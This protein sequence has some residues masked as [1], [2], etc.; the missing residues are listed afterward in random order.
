MQLRSWLTA[1]LW[2][3]SLLMFADVALATPKVRHGASPY[4][5]NANPC[6]ERCA[7]S[8]ANPGNW[9]AYPNFKQIKKCQQSV[10]YDFSLYDPVDDQD[11]NHRIY[12]CSSFGP[13]FSNLSN[14]TA[15]VDADSVDVDYEMGWWNEGFGL[16]SAGIRSL[17]KQT[18]QYLDNGHGIT[19]RPFIMFARSG[20]A[21]IG[22]FIGQGLQNQGLSS[23][24]LKTFED[25]LSNLNVTTPSLAMQLCGSGYDSSH[26]FGLMV[27]SNT[28]FDPIQEAIKNW[29]NAT[30]LSFSGSTNF[31]GQAMFTTPLVDT[32]NSTA[33]SN[34]TAI[35]SQ[36]DKRGQALHARAE[37]ETIQVISGDSCASLAERC[38][39]SA[40][41]FT[42]YN[43]DSSLC[44]SL[45]P[46]Q[47][48]CCTSGD[49]PDL[50]PVTNEDGSCYSY[51][52]QTDDNCANLAVE[53]GLEQ[54][55]LEDFNTN[56]WGWGGCELLYV[57]TIMCLSEGDPPFPSEIA[58]AI[59]GPQVPGTEAPDDDTDIATLNPCPL[60]ACCNIWGQ[61][62]INKDFCVDTNTGAPG[63]A[64][65]GT[66]GC[67]SNCGTDIV[68]GSGDGSIRIAYFEGYGLGRDCLFQ[69]A[70]QIDASAYTYIHFAFGTLTTDYEVEVGD[71]L[72]TYQFG[73]FKRITDAKKILSFGGWD[74][75]TSPS[76][77]FIF[78][79]GTTSANRLKM[80][81]NIANFIKKHELDGVDIDW[82]YPGAPDIPDIPA[83]GEDEG[84][85]YLAFLVI[86]KNLL[87][88]K[89]ISIAA[90]ASYW[91]LKQ[92]PIKSIAKIVDYI[93][94]MT[95]DL[96]GQWDADNSDSQEGCDTG[97]C[98][99]SQ[100]NLT[101]TK[102]SLAMITKAGV[103]SAKVIVGVTSYGRSFN[104]AEIGCYGPNCLYTGDR[105][106][107]EATKGICTGTAGYIAD[108]EIYEIIEDSS[109]VV[110]SY[111]DSTSNSNILV[112]DDNQWVS[113]MSSSTKKIR[114]TLYTAWAMGG[115]TDW[116]SDLQTYN[117]V[118]EFATSWAIFKEAI[119]AGTDPKTDTTVTGNWTD[120]YCDHDVVDNP[121][122]YTPSQRW[123]LLGCD[124]AW[125]DATR[126]YKNSY[127]DRDFSFS[128]SVAVIFNAADEA[129]CESLLSD[130][131]ITSIECG[132][133]FDSE[134]SGP[135][136]WLIWNSLVKIHQL[137]ADY[138]D[139][140]F[141]SAIGYIAGL[142]DLENKFAPVPPE[143]DTTWLLVL[144]DIITIGA[145]TAA[146]PFFNA[147]LKKQK[148]F[149]TNDIEFNNAKD[150][151][152]TLI[153]QSTTLAKDL[154]STTIDGKKWTVESQDSFS[155]YMGQVINGWANLTAVSLAAIFNG[156][157]S[158][159]DTLWDVISDG[160]LITGSF[161]TSAGTVTE[162]DLRANI[163]RTFY[164]YSI[165]ILWQFSATWAFVM[166]S[167]YS[168]SEDKELSSYLDD[169]TMEATGACYDGNQ[170]YL[171]YPK[172]DSTSCHSPPG[173]DSLDGDIFGKLTVEEL[174]TGSVRTYIKNG[175]KN[176]DASV[177]TTD[178][179]TLLSLLDIDIT[180]PGYI[181]LPVCSPERAY[182][183]WDT[184]STGSST[185]YPCDVPPGID[186]CGD[187][188]FE[189][190][191]SD[192]SPTVDDCKTII[193]NI[194]GDATTEWTT[195]VVGEEQREIAS[196]GSC[197]FGVEATETTGNANFQV[198]GQDVIDI[199][200]SAIN[201][202]GGSGN[203][204]AQGEMDCNGNIKDQGVKWGIYH[205]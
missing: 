46:K 80:A 114:Q 155:N 143:E 111:L 129:T 186:N 158:S 79:E 196:Y 19:D 52:I 27:T 96:H 39:I 147:F 12:A 25:N 5:R 20:K 8:G 24:A 203:I 1:A 204:G 10:F 115:T 37:C 172:G 164:A 47:H 2:A 72:S 132:T 145:A 61:C 49:L 142:S 180:T 38:G 173:L 136:G 86:L 100:V 169:D 17:V 29:A 26:I 128:E 4:Y 57:G 21:S 53:Y 140:L 36:N 15:A 77:Y 179:D 87:P 141:N 82:E 167:G 84:A 65:A 113:Y 190:N 120:F 126:I 205:T 138:H 192:A 75:S 74:F 90:P 44:S 55:D 193:T 181:R 42:K 183:S 121:F 189:D 32:T 127:R 102:S 98:L 171:V 146:G 66:Y 118:P 83:G 170:Y 131:C 64:E 133:G 13:D 105:L 109:R 101:E 9:S 85:N 157:D 187:S 59:C 7:V 73:E 97:N 125:D 151:T 110:K 70:L 93:V 76:T 153:S 150:T 188:S 156:S 176:T 67:I 71:V 104:M 148:Y 58:N 163:E 202:F 195:L 34:S 116:A 159:I 168:C 199:I 139:A 6:P 22:V 175:K 28:T 33:S 107:S 16:A 68:K 106:N 63:T 130:N 30:C 50:R 154:L 81:T 56:T 103:D 62:G 135:A 177:D 35:S 51:E 41:D 149:M 144:I 89:T 112:Y 60:N 14:S 95:Y 69:D 178:S 3:T 11:I 48:V 191:T 88:G 182:Q 78:R 194:E 108:A 152:L 23:S 166:D 119:V 160:K 18:R 184:S 117:E 165:P 185:Y 99:R 94:Y 201:R 137:Y 174:I 162:P 43:S 91:Y 40:S 197:A 198:G 134:S 92:Y 122:D 45:V 31:T 123:Q 54:E 200:N 124:A 161:S